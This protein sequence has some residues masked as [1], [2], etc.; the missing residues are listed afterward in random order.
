MGDNAENRRVQLQQMAL[1]A[2]A[3][4]NAAGVEAT[5]GPGTDE[6]HNAG[7]QPRSGR[8]E[9]PN[10][11][12]PATQMPPEAMAQTPTMDQVAG[13]K[14]AAEGGVDALLAQILT[15][16]EGEAKTAA[17]AEVFEGEEVV[18][19][20]AEKIAEDCLA[21]GRF[22]EL[23]FRMGLQKAAED[24][25]LG[26]TMLPAFQ[27]AHEVSIEKLAESEAIDKLAEALAEKFVEKLQAKVSG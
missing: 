21:Q 23:G 8:Q 3:Q 1:A 17:E 15:Q 5:R 19:T 20:A 2:A 26:L 25:S 11:A 6:G 22:V 4:Q 7:I 24:G 9:Y 27:A 18:K 16:G 14:A 10:V 13:T 12:A